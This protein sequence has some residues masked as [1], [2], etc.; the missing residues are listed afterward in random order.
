MLASSFSKVFLLS[1]LVLLLPITASATFAQSGFAYCFGDG[2]GTPCPCV[3]NGAPG[4]GCL[5]SGMT[6]GATLTASGNAYTLNDTFQLDVVGV[7]GNK[8]GLIIRGASQLNG[9]LGNAVGDGLL[10]TGGQVA[11]S[12]VQL[13]SGGTA[14]F[15]DFQ[16]NGFGASNYGIGVPTNYQFWYRDPGNAC[17]GT[18]FNFSNAWSVVWQLDDSSVPITGMVQIPAGVFLMG[19]NA[20][21][22]A[23][24]WGASNEKPVHRVTISEDFWMSETEITQ[25]QYMAM[26]GVNPSH[27]SGVNLPVEKVSWNDAVAYCAALTSQEQTAGNLVSGYEYRLPTEA[28]WEYACRAGTTTEFNVGP[29]L[30]C[31]QAQF[32]Y[33]YHSN[34]SCNPISTKTV[35]G[36]AP[37][38]FGLYDMHGNVWEWCLDSY[39]AYS[40]GSVTDPFVLGGPYRVIRGGSLAFDSYNCRSAFR[41]YV[42][43][44]LLYNGIG[45]RVVLSRV[46]VP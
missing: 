2:T 29:D 34:S 11:R 7:P 31:G 18:G 16:G 8:P 33:S 3:G 40:A 13:T 43:P 9:G 37:N 22:G 23:P 36:Y 32:G 35:G 20:A 6:E 39:A 21:G 30:F 15:S 38:A 4:E 28:E 19:S 27:F 45:F 25:E 24:Y 1:F 44:G 17:S 5:N 12:Q 41:G 26:M 10:C 14:T 42:S 46:L